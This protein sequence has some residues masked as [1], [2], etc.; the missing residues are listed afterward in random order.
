M[1]ICSINKNRDPQTK[2]WLLAPNIQ[3]SGSKL[4]IFIPSG[5]LE[6]HRS[7]FS[8]W[9][10]CLIGPLIWGYRKFYSIPPKNGFLAQKRPNLA[11]KWHFRHFWPIWSNARP[12]KMWFSVVWVPKRLLTSIKSRIFGPKMAL[13][14][15]YW[16]FLPILSHAQP[17]NNA[18]K[19]PRWVFRYAGKQNFSFLQ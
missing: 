4:H 16:H 17:K 6:P 5:Q 12:K 15:K 8:T 13:L 9:K 10:R 7:M 2:K 1:V 14:A 18:N 3:I 19:V 11:H